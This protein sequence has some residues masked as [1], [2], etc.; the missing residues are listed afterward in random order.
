M[1]KVKLTKEEILEVFE[2]GFRKK[3]LSKFY[4][5]LEKRKQTDLYLDAVAY[6]Y[7]ECADPMDS[8]KHEVDCS[9]G[10]DSELSSCFIDFS[11]AKEGREFW[12]K[13]NT[14][15]QDYKDED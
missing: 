1:E 3:A 13:F 2:N 4:A 9:G 11:S 10:D 14:D 12:E 15:W 8:F 7:N 5:F 6:T